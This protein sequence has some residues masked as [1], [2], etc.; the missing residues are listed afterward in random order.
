M[1][2][3]VEEGEQYTILWN[4]EKLIVTVIEIWV[5]LIKLYYPNYDENVLIPKKIFKQA[6]SNFEDCEVDLNYI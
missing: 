2:I 5:D 6:L 1:L 4:K 3:N